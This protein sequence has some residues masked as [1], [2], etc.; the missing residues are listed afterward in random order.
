M[1][2]VAKDKHPSLLH[3]EWIKNL[4]LPP[5]SCFVYKQVNAQPIDI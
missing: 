2:K 1:E 3:K 4:E 5:P